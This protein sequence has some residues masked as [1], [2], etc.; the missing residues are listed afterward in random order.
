MHFYCHCLPHSFCLYDIEY[1]KYPIYVDLGRIFCSLIAVCSYNLLHIINCLS[2][3]MLYYIPLYIFEYITYIYLLHF[4][5]SSYFWSFRI[6]HLSYCP[7]MSWD[8]KLHLVNVLFFYFM[9][10]ILCYIVISFL[11]NMLLYMLSWE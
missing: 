9:I 10:T 5:L 4:L 1:F 7:F 8:I 6:Y 3:L 2:M 11:I